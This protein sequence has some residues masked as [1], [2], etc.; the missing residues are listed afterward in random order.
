[1]GVGVL[2]VNSIYVGCIQ[3]NLHTG[4]GEGVHLIIVFDADMWSDFEYVFQVGVKL[5]SSEDVVWKEFDGVMFMGHGG[6]CL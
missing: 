5:Y 6:E 3:G 1:M 4:L 2:N